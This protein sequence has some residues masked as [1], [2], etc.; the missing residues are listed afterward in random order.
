MALRL[1]WKDVE[2]LFAVT[3]VDCRRAGMDTERWVLGQ[4]EHSGRALMLIERG[5]GARS[6]LMRFTTPA[7]ADRFF[8]GMRFVAA[9]LTVPDV[10]PLDTAPVDDADAPGNAFTLNVSTDNAAFYDVFA[11]DVHAPGMELARILRSVADDVESR[12][13]PDTGTVRD[14]NGAKVGSWELTSDATGATP[15]E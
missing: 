11:P 13:V 14:A 3:V 4:P 7:D 8:Q 12:C 6:V 1:T 10:H 9:R 2:Q 5:T 15:R